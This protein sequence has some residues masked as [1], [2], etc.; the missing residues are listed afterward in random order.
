MKIYISILFCFIP[1]L[2]FAQRQ[3]YD[4]YSVVVDYELQSYNSRGRLDEI[5]EMVFI[6]KVDVNSLS[7]SVVFAMAQDSVPDEEFVRIY[8]RDISERFLGEIDI[9]RAVSG[10]NKDIESQ[11]EINS[12]KIKV[13]FPNIK[14]YS[15]N[16]H[17]DA[18]V[19]WKER[20][21]SSIPVPLF[22]FTKISYY[23]NFASLYVGE[24]GEGKVFVL[25]K[26]NSKW[27]VVGYIVV[28]V[29]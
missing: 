2:L 18:K 20:W 29:S 19:F 10:I 3:D 21:L 16:S 15:F 22:A 17:D 7:D 9:R 4:I 1:V 23:K 11:P 12:S 5:A 27:V 13:N 8:Y 25:E 14:R 28:W 24:K 26:V 6:E